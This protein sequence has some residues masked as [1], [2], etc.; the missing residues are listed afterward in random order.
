[1]I[2]HLGPFSPFPLSRAEV[3]CKHIVQL[4]RAEVGNNRDP[5]R[6][7]LQFASINPDNAEVGVRRVLKQAGM[8]VPVSIDKVDLEVPALKKYPVIKIST[9]ARYLLDTGRLVRQM[10]GVQSFQ[11]MR[12]V[13]NEFW[14]RL[15]ALKPD[16]PVFRLAD[17]NELSLPSAIPFFSHTDEGRSFKHLPLLVISI[18]GC[19]GRGTKSYLQKSKHMARIPQN[20]MGL[21]FLGQTFSTNFMFACMLRTVSAEHPRA[22]Q[23]LFE[24]FAAD[25]EWL[26]HRGVRSTDGNRH[27][28]LVHLNTKGDLPA[29]VR[30]GGFKRSYSH[31]P[32]GQR[33]K[34]PCQGICH[35]CLAGQERNDREGLPAVPFEDVAMDAVWTQTINAKLPW[36]AEPAIIAGLELQEKDQASFFATD[37]WHNFHLGVGKQ[38]VGSSFVCIVESGLACLPA[39]AIEAKFVYLTKLYRDFFKGKR[40]TPFVPELSRETF[41]WPQSNATPGAKW[42]KGA[43]TTQMMMFLDWFAKTEIVGKTEDPILLNIVS[44]QLFGCSILLFLSSCF[45]SQPSAFNGCP[46]SVCSCLLRWPLRLK[47]RG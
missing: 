4:V 40:E 12:P 27:V 9:W 29:L 30:L 47:L 42:S 46:S 37:L 16:H 2:A 33:T 13:L 22:L 7:M 21:N 19:L 17:A 38:Y 10:V 43:A 6:I 11:K 18:H 28:W 31:V 44:A 35:L 34:K 1:M 3:P 8:C 14:A 5:S 25:C 15:K 24:I 26:M 36:Q 45:A 41:I 39:G 32:K 23:K 20:E